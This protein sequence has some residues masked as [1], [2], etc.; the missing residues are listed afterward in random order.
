MEKRVLTK[1]YAKLGKSASETYQL[2]KQVNGEDCLSRSNVSV[3]RKCISDGRDGIEYDQ[4]SGRPISSRTP[5]V[6]EKV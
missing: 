6:I 5:E 4:R 2:I 1:F 3:W